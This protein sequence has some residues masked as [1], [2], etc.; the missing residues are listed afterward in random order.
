[1]SHPPAQA[2]GNASQ[3]FVSRVMTQFIIHC[4]E[5]VQVNAKH[6]EALL[7][8]LSSGQ[9]LFQSVFGNRPVRQ[10]GESIVTGLVQ[11]SGMH[12]PVVSSQ[13]Y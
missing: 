7:T 12:L 3:Q 8:S 2:D 11:K 5:S 1:M 9:G 10:S 4:F 6:S 13:Q